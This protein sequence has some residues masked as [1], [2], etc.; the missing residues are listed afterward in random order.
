[1]NDD[2]TIKIDLPINGPLLI[3]NSPGSR[4]PSHKTCRLGQ[5][6]AIDL[7]P[8]YSPTQLTDGRDWQLW[9]SLVKIQ[10]CGGY[11]ADIHSI[12]KGSVALVGNGCLDPKFV[13]VLLGFLRIKRNLSL[14]HI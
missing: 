12:A 14:I 4:I 8:L 6:Y 5:K 13:N 3:N 2:T 11:G 9:C 10:H 7:C 1:M